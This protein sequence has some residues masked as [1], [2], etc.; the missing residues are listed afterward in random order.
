MAQEE[1]KD[2][3]RKKRK[4]KSDVPVDTDTESAPKASNGVKAG[5]KRVSFA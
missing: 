4:R 5:R 1:T 3:M 2:S